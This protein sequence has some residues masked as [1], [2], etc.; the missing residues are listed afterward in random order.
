[1]A[2]AVAAADTR[3]VSAAVSLDDSAV[4]LDGAVIR[5]FV[6]AADTGAFLTSRSFYE[7]FKDPDLCVCNGACFFAAADT[8]G[9]L[10][11]LGVDNTA[12]DIDIGVLTAHS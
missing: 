7:R 6:A 8:R 1:M 10:T 9:V 11:A 4:D 12:L 5:K 3:G 2:A